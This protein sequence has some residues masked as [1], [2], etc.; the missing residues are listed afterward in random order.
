MFAFDPSAVANNKGSEE[1]EKFV[2]ETKTN[3]VRAITNGGCQLGA[4]CHAGGVVVEATRA[5]YV[6]F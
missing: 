1:Y 4:I 3:M 5:T 2:V 6:T